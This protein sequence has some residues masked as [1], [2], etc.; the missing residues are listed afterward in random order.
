MAPEQIRRDEPGPAID[1]WALGVVAFECLTGVPPFDGTSLIE[2]F[3]RIQAGRHLPVR[4][5]APD[6]PAEFE[7]WFS[8]ACSL[9]PAARFR[10]ATVAARALAVSLESARWENDRPSLVATGS[11]PSAAES[12]AT[13][14]VPSTTLASARLLTRRPR[15]LGDTN[16]PV[17][18]PVAAPAGV[19]EPALPSPPTPS[20]RPSVRAPLASF[21]PP[22][23]RPPW[24]L[25]AF[26]ALA[27]VLAGGFLAWRALSS[28]NGTAP[29]AA[30]AAEILAPAA[31]T[32]APQAL[33]A[34]AT[35]GDR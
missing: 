4:E 12:S 17:S 22:R 32:A 19:P 16:A 33:P 11:N 14:A 7:E 21:R 5:L 28:R 29:P 6:L 9:D 23:P 26:A 20:E 3:T 30:P 35:T 31:P 25:A 2:I 10:S 34:T 8:M 13:T 1:I 15:E 18:R 27:L 24:A